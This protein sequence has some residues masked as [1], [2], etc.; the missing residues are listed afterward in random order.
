M[1]GS[2][3]M[4][5]RRR[6]LVDEA[7]QWNGNNK[8]EVERFLGVTAVRYQDNGGPVLKVRIGKST[9]H[10]HLDDWVVKFAEH[11]FGVRKPDIFEATYGAAE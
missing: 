7:V 9:Y 4:K 3:I 2:D 6:P 1:V 5:Y 10:I 11:T 8:K